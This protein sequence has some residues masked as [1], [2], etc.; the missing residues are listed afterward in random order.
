MVKKLSKTK[1]AGLWTSASVIFFA[2]AVLWNQ[3]S[4][5]LYGTEIAWGGLILGGITLWRVLVS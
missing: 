2:L 4:G 1:R 5:N 3:S